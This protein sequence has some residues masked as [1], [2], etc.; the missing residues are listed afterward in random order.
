[1]DKLLKALGEFFKWFFIIAIFSSIGIATDRPVLKTATTFVFMSIVFLCVYIAVTRQKRHSL[2][3]KKQNAISSMIAGGILMLLGV[4]T[5]VYLLYNFRPDLFDII[6][7]GTIVAATIAFII[8][9]IVSAFLINYGKTKFSV[10]GFLG[11]ILLIILCAMPGLGVSSVDST[12]GTMGVIYYT[13]LIVAIISWI[14]FNVLV[15]AKRYK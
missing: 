8:I 15:S 11:Y 12:F 10:Q 3:V 9:T 2:K 6:G 13:I 5:P 7:L 14:G 1:M 4:F